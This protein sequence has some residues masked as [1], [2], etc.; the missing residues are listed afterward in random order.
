MLSWELAAG[1][2]WAPMALS[3]SERHV[4]PAWAIGPGLR[5]RVRTAYCRWSGA[6]RV[7]VGDAVGLSDFLR[8]LPARM[9]EVAEHLA[10]VKCTP[11][12]WA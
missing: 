3:D 4:G 7:L 5:F 10:G 8:R 1:F 12:G 6:V 9:V 2:E 11:W